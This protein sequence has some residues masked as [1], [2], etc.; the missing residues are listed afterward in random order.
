MPL[1]LVMRL[2]MTSGL[3]AGG[4]LSRLEEPTAPPGA[5]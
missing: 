3:A 4:M 1:K 2:E 5:P